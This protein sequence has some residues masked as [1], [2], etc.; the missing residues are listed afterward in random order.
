MLYI[1]GIGLDSN[2]VSLKALEAIKKCSRI[3][4]ESYTSD[5]PYN[6]EELEQVLKVKLEIANRKFVEESDSWLQNARNENIA[7]LVSG[8][9]LVATTHKEILLRAEKFQVKVDLIHSVSVISAVAETGLELYKFGK[10][11]SIPRWRENFKPESFFDTF[12]ENEK[13]S[14]HTL[15]L[16]DQNLDLNEALSYLSD[17]GKKKKIDIS[18]RECLICS[19]LGTEKRKIKFGKMKEFQKMNFEKP[20]CIIFPSGLNFV[21]KEFIGKFR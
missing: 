21:E 8:D 4:L 11:A 7:L 20:Y 12:L 3:Y 16:V 17:I 9:P 2:D 14:A 19:Q 5:F 1:I 6:I 18:E 15:F 13:I 10:I